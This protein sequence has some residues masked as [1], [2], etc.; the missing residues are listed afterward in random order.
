MAAHRVAFIGTGPDPYDQDWG[1]SAAM[2]YR[3]GWGYEA[4][5]GCELVACTDL[6]RDN[7][8]AFADEFDITTENVFENYEEML[9]TVEPDVVSVATPVPTHA[10]IVIDVAET[11]IPTAVHCEKPMADTWGDSQRMAVACRDAGIQLT[12]NHQR[13]FDP[14]WREAKRL[15]DEGAIGD[16]ER[17]EI[18]G[19]NLF[20]FGAH[21]ID[22]CNF[23]NDEH[24]PRW[25][26]AGLDYRTTDVRY[27]TH[28]ENQS[29]ALWEY[30]NGLTALAATGKDTGSDVIGCLNRLVGSDGVIEVQG[31]EP[32]RVRRACESEW[33]AI[34]VPEVNAIAHGIE[35]VLDC[36]ET[37]EEPELGADNALRA[38]ELIFAAYESVRSHRRVEFPLDAEDNALEAMVNTGEL[39]PSE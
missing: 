29:I 10:D 2:A 7:A 14:R 34:D 6:V 5:D 23:Y 1:T 12:F 27:G 13:R 4:Y 38:M 3:H 35:H 32:L 24:D 15:L 25:M 18:G 39:T 11:E 28:N 8:E 21:L 31:K 20:D 36:L 22:L 37:G 26:L 16:L 9:R 30:E 19:K 17:L 33:E